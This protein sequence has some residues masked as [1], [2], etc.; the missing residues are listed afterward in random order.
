M[1]TK[2]IRIILGIV[3]IFIL[4]VITFYIL[5]KFK[6]NNE[7]KITYEINNKSEDYLSEYSEK[8]YYIDNTDGQWNYI[9]AMGGRNSGGHSIEITN[10]E[11]DEKNNVKV[12]VK[13]NSP[14]LK[15]F[16]SMAFTY[17][18]CELKLSGKPN[19]ITIKDVNGNKYKKKE[20]SN[21]KIQ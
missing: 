1:K 19:S 5:Y 20:I 17:P 6:G 14:G 3:L 11:I 8:G 2:K 15:E 21:E 12:T 4:L 16:V 18:N 7:N 10:V 13:E 9:I